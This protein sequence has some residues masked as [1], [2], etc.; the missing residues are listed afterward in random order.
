MIP[1]DVIVSSVH[2]R[3]DLLDR[4]LR[5]MLAALDQRPARILVHEDVRPELPFE[6]GRTQALCGAVERELG[7]P[8]VVIQT[9]PGGGLSLAMAQLLEAASTEFV[10]Y[11]QEDFDFVREVPVG[12]CLEIMQRHAL[13]HVR[14]NK[15]DTLPVKGAHRERSQWWT[16]QE[17]TFDGQTFCVSDHV[18]YQAQITRRAL[19]LEGHKAILQG[20]PLGL[21]RCE[22]HFNHWFNTRYGGGAGSVD[23]CQDKRRDLLRT[24]IWG[25]VGEPRFALHTGAVRR[26]QGWSDPEHDRKHGTV[27]GTR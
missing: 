13:T 17:V 8:V 18:Y 9:N 12:R 14:F 11:T 4:T 23:G 24:F 19:W 15:R 10:F 6:A 2:D 20:H 16:K 5:S 3:A 22:A 1:F 7:V 21:P 26:S 27:G 25:G